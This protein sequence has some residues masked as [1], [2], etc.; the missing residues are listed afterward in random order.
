[1][2][3]HYQTK[4]NG[5]NKWSDLANSLKISTPKW[6]KL[7]KSGR[8][9]IGLQPTTH[10]QGMGV[11]METGN[12]KRNRAAPM[13]KEKWWDIM[14]KEGTCAKSNELKDEDEAEW[15]RE[16]MLVQEKKVSIED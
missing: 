15:F 8:V 1:M 12:E 2:M 6:M 9:G 14:A 13:M 16:F 11:G 7:V 5:Q 3:N 4:L 10:V